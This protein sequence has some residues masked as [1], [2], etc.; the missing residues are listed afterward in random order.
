MLST[1]AGTVRPGPPGA[2]VEEVI[3][4]GQFVQVGVGP[5]LSSGF[6]PQR[7][8]GAT[9]FPGTLWEW[10]TLLDSSGEAESFSQLDER[11][12]Y[13]YGAIYTSPFIGTRHA[14]PGSTYVQAFKDKDG[15]RLDGS[16][17]YRL[18]V[19]ANTPA[20][21]FW[22]L[23]LYDTGTRSMVQSPSNDAA[24]SS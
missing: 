4:D 13:T 17:S 2:L 5:G 12:G 10:S 20:T 23:T 14:G 19:P 6:I 9:M 16:R 1:L 8:S 3:G 7:I 24:H 21:A 22:S 18:H 15:N 11:L